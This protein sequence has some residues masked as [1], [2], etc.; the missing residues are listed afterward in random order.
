MNKAVLVIVAVVAPI[1]CE[2]LMQEALADGSPIIRHS[3][4]VRQICRDLQCGPYAP[5]GL[6][7]RL[8]CPD[9]ASCYS[10]YVPHRQFGPYEP[11]GGVAYWGRLT[12]SGWFYRWPS[13]PAY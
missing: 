10:L 1:F 7:C 9:P 12:Q 11:Y 13:G 6:H 5:C 2:C 4:K 8:A 3:K